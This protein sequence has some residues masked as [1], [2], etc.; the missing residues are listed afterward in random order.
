MKP[1]AT[2]VPDDN[3][4][5]HPCAGRINTVRHVAI[6]IYVESSAP[7]TKSTGGESTVSLKCYSTMVFS[8]SM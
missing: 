5:G 6:Y 7:T 1:I 8:I 3:T 2:F 4:L